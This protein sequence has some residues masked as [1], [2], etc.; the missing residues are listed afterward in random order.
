MDDT[1]IRPSFP[2]PSSFLFPKAILMSAHQ[3]IIEIRRLKDRGF[4][5]STVVPLSL[6]HL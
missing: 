4:P 1:K 3:E 2:L 6:G 5:A